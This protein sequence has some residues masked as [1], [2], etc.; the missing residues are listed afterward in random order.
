MSDAPETA[1]QERQL[2]ES[3]QRNFMAP[4]HHRSVLKETPLGKWWHKRRAK[5]QKHEGGAK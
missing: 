2:I 5:K 3:W 1:K 4:R